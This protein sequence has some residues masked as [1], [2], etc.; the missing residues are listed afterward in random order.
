M[1]NRIRLALIP[2]AVASI[3]LAG[4]SK[5]EE[6]NTNLPEA[7]TLLSESAATTKTQT[8][9][10]IV[11]K[12][13]GDKPTLK[14]SELTGDLTTTPAVAA[15]GTAKTGGLELPF[16]VVDGELFAQLGSAYT[17]MGPVK[18]VY[19]I[20]IILD[21]NKGLANLLS[22]IKDAKSEKTE[23]VDGVASVLVSGTMNKDAINTFA[24]SKLTS[25]IPAKAWIAKDG[26]HAL[27]KISVDTSPGNTIEMSLSDW[28]KPVTV[29]KPA[30]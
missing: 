10:H 11:L 3:A 17:T 8:S 19:D 21:P 9:T 29:D 25:D 22:N 24:G 6:T 20:G 5:S 13:T 16:V 30:A 28:G 2:L 1:R 7:A 4:C 12:V 15:K 26:N 18:D 23:T 27:T 14:L